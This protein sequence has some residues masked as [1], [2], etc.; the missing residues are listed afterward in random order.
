[1]LEHEPTMTRQPS[2]RAMRAPSEQSAKALVRAARAGVG[3]LAASLLSTFSAAGASAQAEPLWSAMP[4]EPLA[5]SAAMCLFDDVAAGLT[6][7]PLIGSPVMGSPVMGSPVMGPPL[8]ST[9]EAVDPAVGL[10]VLEAAHPLLADRFELARVERE[11]ARWGEG[12]APRDATL[13]ALEAA[14]AS[15]SSAIA[16]RARVA[17]ARCLLLVDDPSASEGLEALLRRYPELPD[18]VSLRLE[19]ARSF[20]RRGRH[21][22]AAAAFRGIDLLHPGAH[23]GRL[24]REGLAA[25]SAAGHEAEPL[26]PRERVE[27][28]ARLVRSGPPDL[29][30]DE[31]AVLRELELP[32]VLAAE[33]FVLSARTAR[34]E[35]RFVD[36]DAYTARARELDPRLA[37]APAEPL[38]RP[39]SD[40]VAQSLRASGL[41]VLLDASATEAQR[42]RALRR[43]SSARLLEAV[44]A[45]ARAGMETE[46]T[47]LT[48]EAARRAQLPCGV[49]FEIAVVASGAASDE[50]IAAL[51]SRCEADAAFGVRVR[52]L[53]ARALER[54]E[55]RDEAA[56]VYRDVIAADRS[57]TGFYALWAR[58]R[59]AAIAPD[60][61]A[62]LT[63]ADAAGEGAARAPTS[64]EASEALDVAA[65]LA[66]LRASHGEAYPWLARAHELVLLGDRAAAREELHELYLAWL[67][68][69]GRGPIRAGVEAVYRGATRQRVLVPATVR[70]LRRNLAGEDAVALA[71]VAEA[72]GDVGLAIRFG[73]TSRF[74]ARP[75]AFEDL[76]VA[77]A[78]RHDLDPNLL[79]AV[80]RVESVY[81]PEIVSYAGA[82]GLLQIMPRTGRLIAHRLGLTDF[83]TDDLLDPATNIELAA[84][85]LRSLLDR[86]EGRLPLAIAAY[87]GGPHNVR[88]W[89]EEHGPELPLDAF[90]ERIPFDQT[91]RYVRRVLSHYAAYRAQE[92][93][94]L[95]ELHTTLPPRAADTV[96]F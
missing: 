13:C 16:A 94:A 36:A 87:N 38:A 91:F 14:L 9:V 4:S 41:G 24:A 64:T 17:R 28:A 27:R 62:A 29:A 23:E 73:G 50:S 25:L 39:A 48:E 67:D 65:T 7:S 74:S 10:E 60:V 45:T 85:Y 49:R 88:R 80:M 56:T 42:N 35:G 78:A 75:R 59:L 70:R 72:L 68:A 1:M 95:P 21:V 89:M 44:R 76:V 47:L 32:S 84:W 34:V 61:L 20:A 43:A 93:L 77:A 8:P 12:E 96:A 31:L 86:F 11:L 63:P 71:Q 79:L 51:A 19:E 83:R 37:L 57:D 53:H 40:V 66:S 18:E 82:I 3:A 69:R 58:Q 33:V 26:T 30:R 81:D 22:E 54:M 52:Y 90:L 6:P 46:A 92:G 5:S 55:R 2:S 15:P